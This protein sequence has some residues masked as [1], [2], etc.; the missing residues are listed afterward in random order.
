MSRD[1]LVG[2]WQVPVS[3]VGVTL[4]D[5]RHL[6]GEAMAIGERTPAALLDAA[7]AARLAV[8]EAITNI[9]AAD[10]AALSEVRLS[11]NWM[12]ACGVDGEDAALYAAVQ[13]GGRGVLPAAGDSDSGR[14][15]LAIDA[16]AMA[17]GWR[18]AIGHRTGVADRIGLRAG[19]ERTP[20]L[21]TGAAIGSRRQ[22]AAAHR[23]RHAA[24]TASA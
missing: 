12:A 9:M 5:Y 16:Y 17:A 21:D 24:A 20:H 22:C 11:A 10:I 8:A 23:P 19:A 2:P 6:R 13:R 7:A 4:A 1:Q 3:D 15:R 18:A 14:K